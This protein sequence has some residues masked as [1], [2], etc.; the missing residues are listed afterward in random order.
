M[1]ETTNLV[2]PHCHAVNRVP[3]ARLAE[4]PNCG[5]CKRPLFTGHPLALGD[6][7]F[8][9]FLSRE[10][11]PLVVDFWAPWCGPCRMMAPAYEQ[12]SARI[13]PRARL[14]KVDT[15]QNPGLAQRYGIRSIPT[16]AV[17]KR[18]RQTASQAGAL[19]PGQLVQWIEAQL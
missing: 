3:G 5:R 1:A 7:D 12:A 13:E 18:G 4:R 6:Q 8:D 14:V 17:F 15:E 11:L 9:R 16:L 19:G 2:C 10:E